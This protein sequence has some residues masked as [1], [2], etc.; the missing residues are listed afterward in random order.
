MRIL[1]KIQNMA[2]IEGTEKYLAVFPGIK[3][4]VLGKTGFKVSVCG[5]GCYRIEDG[6]PRHKAALEKA[7][8]SG[9]NLIDTS[10]N[11]S[12]GASE[13]L[14]G[15]VLSGLFSE[16]KISRD[17]VI[18]V[19]KGG[20]IQGSNF[21]IAADRENNNNPF[22][23]VVKCS[24]DLWHCISPDFLENQISLSLKRLQLDK[25]DIYLL[26]NPEYFLT[27]SS[28]LDNERREKEYYKRVKEAFLYLEKEI[29]AGRISFYGIS[30]NTFGE[31]NK[32]LNFTSLEKVIGIAKEISED[33]H[34]AVAQFPMNLIEKGGFIKKNQVN[35][36]KTFLQLASENNLGVLVNRPLNAIR[37]NQLIRLADYPVTEN[38]SDEEIL[39][40]LDDLA[41]QEKNI[42]QKYINLIGLTDTEEKNLINYISVSNI[43]KSNYNK[44]DSTGHFNEIKTTYIIPRAN[45][46]INEIGKSFNNDE[47][48]TRALRNYAV[49]T[50][51]VLDSIY[52]N[53]AKN[54]NKE[55]IIFHKAINKIANTEQQKLSLSQKAILLINSIPQVTV[56]LVGM[57][58][59][60]YVQDVIE[61]AKQDY[62]VNYSEF[63]QD[64]G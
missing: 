1:K 36:T 39:S 14:V 28:I 55:N 20:Y 63:W 29:Q 31:S 3:S 13:L 34:F 60:D 27:Y 42:I 43:L 41:N 6:I 46:S 7:L 24:P 45:Y 12:D 19:S 62:F 40:L 10:S 53:L 51:I 59:V 48:V 25:I 64:I 30:S 11:Y 44:F 8:L 32:K 58:N 18:V 47:N 4:K 16:G 37:K 50:N 56:T 38:R 22:N 26:H 57:R 33:N 5:F 21:K 61:S 52:S 23:D 2:S 49:T 9:V 15:N 17:N 35:D 54:R